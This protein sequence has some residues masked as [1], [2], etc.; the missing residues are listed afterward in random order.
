MGA[1]LYTIDGMNA[2]TA[3]RGSIFQQLTGQMPTNLSPIELQTQLEAIN[4]QAVAYE[5]GMQ[6]AGITDVDRIAGLGIQN[7]GNATIPDAANLTRINAVQN[8]LAP[9]IPTM[10]IRP[11]A[12]TVAPAGQTAS[13]RQIAAE[14]QAQNA[15][16]QIEGGLWDNGDSGAAAGVGS[17]DIVNPGVEGG[18]WD[19]VPS[20]A[21]T[22]V[23]QPTATLSSNSVSSGATSAQVSVSDHRF[24]LTPKD[25]SI[26]SGG[27]GGGISPSG[28]VSAVDPSGLLAGML[29]Q[30]PEL[31]SSLSGTMATTNN[32]IAGQ[33]LLYPLIATNGFMFPYTPQVQYVGQANYG[34]QMVT[35]SNQ[36]FRYYQNTASTNLT[37]SGPFSAQTQ[38]EAAYLLA[39]IHFL[40]VVTK[41]R[42]G[43]SAAPGTPPPVLVLNGYGNAMFY[44]LP[45]IVTNF[46]ID[47]P[48]N[49][50]YVRTNSAGLSGWVPSYTTIT[51]TCVVQNTPNKL[52]TFDWDAFAKGS[53]MRTGGW[54]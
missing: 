48:N 4:Q 25:M 51:V 44:N 16:A 5:N 13:D 54:S 20:I 9:D 19:D 53:L 34:T 15:N 32:S 33:S 38:S 49:V 46:T 24:R 26:L 29:Q 50:D 35:H 22:L 23:S 52:R 8:G 39:C 43:N 21:N 1:Q 37:I 41:M 10:T 42:F 17:S 7:T 14:R 28:V 11:S 12:P 45:V 6:A 3:Q 36:E 31:A 40:R 47:M 27:A 2:L 18:T 30:Y